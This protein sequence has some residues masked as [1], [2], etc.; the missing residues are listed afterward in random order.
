M[1]GPSLRD[2][3]MSDVNVA[4]RR[5]H[6]Q[7]CT[8]QGEDADGPAGRRRYCPADERGS[9]MW[10]GGVSRGVWHTD[11]GSRARLSVRVWQYG[12]VRR[13]GARR[14]VPTAWV[15]PGSDV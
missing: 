11:R 2:E 10:R 7:A 1:G 3:A 15:I 12:G 14:R 9:S 5:Q 13:D 8:W 6:R 4:V